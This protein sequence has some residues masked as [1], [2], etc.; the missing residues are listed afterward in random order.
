MAAALLET[1]TPASITVTQHDVVP[2]TGA[3]LRA[4]Y[5]TKEKEV[6][7][8]GHRVVT[9]TARLLARVVSCH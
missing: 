2:L 7:D 4:H 9:A 1:P 3:E 5:E 8:G 6:R